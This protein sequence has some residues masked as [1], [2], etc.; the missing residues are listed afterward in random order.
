MSKILITGPN[1]TGT[2]FLVHLFH[3][4]GF[5]TGFTNQELEKYFNRKLNGLEWMSD[6]SY[7]PGFKSNIKRGKDTSPEVI[8]E[9]FRFKGKGTITAL[10]WAQMVC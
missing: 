5:D 2:T 7:I 3:N 4:L 8:K 1:R 9:P 10:D 6:A